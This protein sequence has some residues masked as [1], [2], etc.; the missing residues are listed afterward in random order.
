MSRYRKVDPRI[1]NDAKFRELSDSAKLVFFMLLTHPGMTSLGAM[2]STIAGLAE[3]L[4]WDQEA[5]RKA[6]GEVSDKGMVQHDPAACFVTIPNFIRY[7]PPESPNVIK[8]WVGSLDLLPECDLKNTVLLRAKAFVDGLTEAYAKAFDEAF[9]KAMPNQ[10]Q[11]QKQ[12]QK[13][14]PQPPA[15]GAERFQDFWE[16]WPPHIRKA[17][18]EQ[19]RRKWASKGLDERADLVIATVL[20]LKDSDKWREE[21]GRWIPAPMTWLNQDRWEAGTQAQ[22][23]A[24]NWQDTRSGI[25][26]KGSELGLGGW[27][28][29][30]FDLGQGEP[31]SAY[32]ARVLR[33]AG[34]DPRRAA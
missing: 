11:E 31:F 22:L 2:R 19:C 6:F 9:A 29:K 10:E 13:K 15:G 25:E 12:K 24:E 20:S 30:A 8:A 14:S 16:A 21:G 1:W 33:A 18:K 17:A 5:F 32:T 4:A 28:Q 27:D 34:I 3:E 7:N 23:H 26:G